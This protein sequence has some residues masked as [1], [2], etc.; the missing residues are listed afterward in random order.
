MK[1][2]D[3]LPAATLQVPSFD[4]LFD[5]GRQARIAIHEGV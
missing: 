1:N 3:T 5:D 4:M 2:W